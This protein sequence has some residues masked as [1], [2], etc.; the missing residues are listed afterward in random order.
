MP[1]FVLRGWDNTPRQTFKLTT[2]K[3]FFALML[4]GIFAFAC[5][6][7]A[8]QEDPIKAKTLE[9]MNSYKS[10]VIAN[11]LHKAIA[12]QED[13]WNWSDTLNT[14]ELDKALAALEEWMAKEREAMYEAWGTKFAADRME[15]F[16]TD[17]HDKVQALDASVSAWFDSLS[18]EDAAMAEQAVRDADAKWWEENGDDYF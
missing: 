17:N 7:N 14:P 2:M 3:R 6:S 13:I 9:Y 1:T 8:Q 12:I 10:A 11:D 5:N 15:A 18:D 16:T 4:V